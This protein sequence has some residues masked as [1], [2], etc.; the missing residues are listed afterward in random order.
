MRAKRFKIFIDQGHN[1]HSHNTGAIANGMHE[2]DIVFDVGIYLHDILQKDFDVMLSRPN[3]GTVLGTNNQSAVNARWQLANAWGADYFISLHV[4]A[5]GGT[6]AETLYFRPDSLEFARTVQDIYSSEMSLHNR[7]VWHRD[8]VGVVRWTNMP[9]VLLELG[10]IDAP[11]SVSVWGTWDVDIL[12]DRRKDM[13]T[14]VAK[15]LYAHLGITPGTSAQQPPIPATPSPDRPFTDVPPGHWSEEAFSEM[16]K[17]GLISG[18]G[19]GT[20]GFGQ[21]METERIVQ[22]MWNVVKRFE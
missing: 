21:P 18:L 6:G 20:V 4:N 5:G 16:H 8:N 7:R 10:F 12:R 2:A 19:D 13:A 14:A 17:L 9:A 15:A 3:H 22:L 1:P 11:V